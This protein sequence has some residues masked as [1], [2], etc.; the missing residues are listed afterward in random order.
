MKSIYVC[1][2]ARAQ[3]YIFV[4]NLVIKFPHFYKMLFVIYLSS[5]IFVIYLSTVIL[6]T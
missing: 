6:I 3:T 4:F 2:Y 1:H 5:V